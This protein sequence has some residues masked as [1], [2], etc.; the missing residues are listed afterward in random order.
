M[1]KQIVNQLVGPTWYWYVLVAAEKMLALSYPVCLCM[2]SYIVS[3]ENYAGWI[4]CCGEKPA[5][6]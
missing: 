1:K 2:V 4:N 5:V 6:T 3:H